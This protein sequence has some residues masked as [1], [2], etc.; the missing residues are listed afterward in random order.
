[1]ATRGLSLFKMLSWSANGIRGDLAGRSTGFC[2]R[3]SHSSDLS[4]EWIEKL[5][6]SER[7]SWRSSSEQR[8]GR[9]GWRPPS[10]INV[11]LQSESCFVSWLQGHTESIPLSTISVRFVQVEV[12]CAPLCPYT[13]WPGLH[14]SA[15]AAGKQEELPFH[16]TPCQT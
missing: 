13:S 5:H 2:F 1:M 3:K 16:P 4:Y 15:A 6:T 11:C 8:A 9:G 12:H 7:I 14:T 10:L